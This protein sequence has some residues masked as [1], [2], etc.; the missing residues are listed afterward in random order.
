MPSNR[1]KNWDKDENPPVNIKFPSILQQQPSLKEKISKTIYRLRTQQNKLENAV[2]RMQRHDR[3]LFDKCVS[4]QMTK[5]SARAAM[6]ANE[7]AEVRKMAA[8]TLRSQLALE[9]VSLR[10]E[11]IREFGEFAAL[12]GP[13]T[14]VVRSVKTQI[15]GIMPEMSYELDDIGETLNGMVVEI[16]EA[17]GHDINIEAPS[18]EASKILGEAETVAEQRVKEKFPDFTSMEVNSTDAS[19]YRTREQSQT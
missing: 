19:D 5:D 16:G 10:L 18:S 12:M 6:Y 3:E 14:E 17:T 9:Q 2:M 8:I 11:T 13:V 1:I 15:S 4:S 7:C